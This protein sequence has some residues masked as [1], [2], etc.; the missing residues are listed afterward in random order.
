MIRQLRKNRGRRGASLL[1]AI[2]VF[3]LAAL[4]GTVALTMAESNAGRYTHEK[5][6][7]QA[8]LAVASASKLILDELG[9]VQVRFTGNKTS[10]PE[11]SADVNEPQFFKKGSTETI[12]NLKLFFKDDEFIDQLKTILPYGKKDEPA[13]GTALETEGY[14]PVSFTLTVD[15]DSKSSVL[16]ELDLHEPTR[17]YIRLW[18]AENGNSSYQMTVTV[19]LGGD[20]EEG[21]GGGSGESGSGAQWE[22]SKDAEGA[23]MYY[24]DLSWKTNEATYTFESEFSDQKPAVE[25]EGT[26]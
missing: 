18:Y 7:Q 11:S 16:V 3:L 12:D 23:D 10:V 17:L 19:G 26:I 1:I 6:D 20:K 24:V 25:E 8:Y 22:T 15:G 4:S 21:E 9:S 14:K 13:A 2:L 5:E